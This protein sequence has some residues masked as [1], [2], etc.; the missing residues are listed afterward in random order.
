MAGIKFEGANE[1]K[2]A[3]KDRANLAD[4][5]KVVRQNGRALQKRM[6]EKA[7]FKGHIGW[8]KGQGKQKISPTGTTKRSIGLEITDG[9]L[10]AEV[11]PETEYSPYLEYGTR[12]MEAQPFVEPALN[13]QAREF[14]QD[15]KK[16]MR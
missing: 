5:K 13:E 3:L 7:D 16:I 4:V 1:L 9:G 14:E 10:S 8:V 15:L 11:G 2:K 12:F 6:Q